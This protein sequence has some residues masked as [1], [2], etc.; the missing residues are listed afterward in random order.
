MSKLRRIA[1]GDFSI[2]QAHTIGELTEADTDTI[3]KWIIPV[4]K[5][6][7]KFEAITANDEERK[8]LFYGAAVPTDTADGKY[9][10]YSS[11]GDFLMLGQVQNGLLK[12]EKSFFEEN[13]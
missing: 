2:E 8:R 1:S 12:K 9:R 10:V 11:G 6:F 4:E 3:R 13:R 5:A 7:L